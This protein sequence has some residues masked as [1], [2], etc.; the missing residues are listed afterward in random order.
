[1]NIIIK[2]DVKNHLR[3]MGRKDM[4]IYTKLMT[5]CWSPRP[6]IFVS[7]REPVVPKD[8]NLYQV[9]GINV[10]LYKEAILEGDAVEI[11]LAKRA[12]DI[13]NKDFH[14]KGLFL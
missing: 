3:M 6:E 8:Y 13:A 9:D 4:T 14:I 11:S 2:E 7:L 1:M 5:S 12:S 10:Y